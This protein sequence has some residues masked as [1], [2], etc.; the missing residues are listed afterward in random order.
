MTLPIS[1]NKNDLR[2]TENTNQLIIITFPTA[3]GAEVISDFFTE[4]FK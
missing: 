2:R 1:N 3:L 4:S